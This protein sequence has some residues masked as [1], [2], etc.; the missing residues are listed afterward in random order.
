MLAGV[1]DPLFAPYSEANAPGA[2][3]AVFHQGSTIFSQ[4]YGLALLEPPVPASVYTNYRLASLTKQFTAAAILRL[5][6]GDQLQLD[7]PV[8]DLLPELADEPASVFHLLTHTSGIWDYED[9]LSGDRTDQVQDCEVLTLLGRADRRYF[10][11]GSAFRYSNS[12]YVLLG[13]IVERVS[14]RPFARFL[15]EQIFAP[16][17]MG[18]TLAYQAG[19]SSVLQRAFGY[20]ATSE[21]FRLTDQSVTSATLGDGGVY[22]SVADLARWEAALVQARVLSSR[23]LEQAWSPARLRDG[24]PIPYGYGWYVDVD[25]GRTRLIHHGETTGFTNAVIRYPSEQ[26]SVWLLTNRTAGAPW[27]LAQEVADHAL[28]LLEGVSRTEPAPAWPFQR[29]A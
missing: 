11:P 25:R 22:S 26:L 19:Q 4:A 5:I 23:T 3:V 14:G 29:T 28:E 15:Q 18:S 6:E 2:S 1:V 10:A 8:A 9:L 12:G 27:D 7:T 16:L 24:T 17:G 21:G 20:S 13:L